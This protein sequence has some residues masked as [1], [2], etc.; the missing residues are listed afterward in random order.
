MVWMK[1]FSPLRD[2]QRGSGMTS[3]ELLSDLGETMK[4]AVKSE[5]VKGE[6]CVNEMSVLTRAL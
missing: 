6:K 3:G 5:K 1:F 4:L 2:T